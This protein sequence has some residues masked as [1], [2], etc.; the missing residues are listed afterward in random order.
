MNNGTDKNETSQA[1]YSNNA[2]EN[3]ACFLFV[4]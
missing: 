1:A 2:P 3:Q 4:S